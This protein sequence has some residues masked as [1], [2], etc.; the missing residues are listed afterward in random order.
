[1]TWSRAQATTRTGHS[2]LV[3]EANVGL[4][5][6]TALALGRLGW[7]VLLACRNL[8]K[9]HVAQSRIQQ[10]HRSSCELAPDVFER[11]LGANNPGCFS[12]TGLAPRGF[13]DQSVSALFCL[14]PR[15]FAFDRLVFQLRSY[16]R[17]AGSL[18]GSLRGTGS[19]YPAGRLLRSRLVATICNNRAESQSTWAPAGRRVMWCPP[20]GSARCQEC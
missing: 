6:E 16:G 3:T 15:F 9:A 20:A 14:C 1:M 4:G 2:A 17:A 11:Q 7:R 10:V 5:Y 19:R 13:F 12:L 8:A 18:R